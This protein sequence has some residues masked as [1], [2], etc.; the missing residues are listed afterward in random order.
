MVR[1]WADPE[2]L[3]AAA[4]LVQREWGHG[5]YR[6]VEVESP[7]FSGAAI[8]TVHATDGGRFYVAGTRHGNTCHA[9]DKARIAERLQE[10]LSQEA[11]G[12]I[13]RPGRTD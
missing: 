12:I 6:I 1:V 13:E 11:V 5:G 10:L 2:A 9:D 3:I 4:C 8:L 7:G